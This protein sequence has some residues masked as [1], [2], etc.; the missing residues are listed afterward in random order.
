M[1]YV[2][3]VDGLASTPTNVSLFCLTTNEIINTIDVSKP[4]GKE[5]R[6]FYSKIM[7]LLNKKYQSILK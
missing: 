2:I 7:K 4:T 5:T 1:E 3:F 6:K